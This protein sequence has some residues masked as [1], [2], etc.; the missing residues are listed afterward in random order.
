LCP[1]SGFKTV[2]TDALEILHVFF[3]L[4]G[5]LARLER[6]EVSAFSGLG[7]FLARIEPLLARRQF[8]DHAVLLRFLG[9]T[10]ER[11]R[12]FPEIRGA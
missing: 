5:G 4:L 3:V 9:E 2:L 10:A 8:A 7:I 11:L 12:Q 6:A 1:S